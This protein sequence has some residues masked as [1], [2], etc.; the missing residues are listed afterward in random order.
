MNS[1]KIIFCLKPDNELPEEAAQMRSRETER[2]AAWLA[3]CGIDTEMCSP[4]AFRAMQCD[5]E[6]VLFT[7]SG[8]LCAEGIRN[9]WKVLGYLHGGNPAESFPG[10]EYVLQEPD[11]ID[12]DSWQK[13]GERLQGMP[14]TILRTERC[15]VRE[16]TEDDLDS[17][18]ELYDEQAL[19]FLE[20]MS[21]D[22]EKE[23][24]ILKAYI[25]EVYGF[26]GCGVW[27]VFLK[28]NDSRPGKLIGRAGYEPFQA[29]DEAVSFGYLIHPDFRGQ[30]YA[31]EVCSA[32]I[33][34]GLKELGFPAV[35][36]VTA[37]DNLASIRLLRR[38]GFRQAGDDTWLIGAGS[39]R[40]S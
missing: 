38:I 37:S 24:E 15:V 32:L 11:E 25:R 19:R 1:M 16:L 28:E 2:T 13:I 8:P 27:G 39:D 21:A 30:G 14:W 12:R 3:E 31:E 4:E 23:R 36:A 7:D 20:G 5:P 10:A 34:Y 22:R 9:G 17:L 18:Y 26:Y 33:R 6:A 35:R 29:G 40:I